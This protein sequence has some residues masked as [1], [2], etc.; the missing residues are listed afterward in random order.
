MATVCRVWHKVSFKFAF[1]VALKS[2]LHK[3][4]EKNR[5]NLFF[6]KASKLSHFVY[7]IPPGE[8]AEGKTAIREGEHFFTN[9]HRI[10][11]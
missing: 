11:G 5:L 9:P 8:F 2:V 1:L 3:Y 10:W 7:T 6:I 4:L